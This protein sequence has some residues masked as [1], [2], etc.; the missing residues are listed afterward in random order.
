M[1][2]KD[3]HELPEGYFWRVTLT[4]FDRNPIVQLRRELFWGLS[5]IVGTVFVDLEE[6]SVRRGATRL[7]ESHIEKSKRHPL[8]GDYR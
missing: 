1:F 7:W 3:L 4:F 8:I 2:S 6:N 5:W